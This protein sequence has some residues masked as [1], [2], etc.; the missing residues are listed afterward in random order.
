[1]GELKAVFFDVRGTLFDSK[2]CAR[3]VMDLVLNMFA[4][5]LPTDDTEEIFRRYNAVLLDQVSS[6][7]LRRMESFSRLKRFSALLES[8]GL[9]KP[10]LAREINSK[11]DATRRLMMRQFLRPDAL[12]VL[13]ALAEQG[14]KR[15][16]IVNGTLALQRTLLS[17][18]GLHE[19]LDHVVMA[20]AEGYHKPDPRLFRKALQEAAVQASEMLYVGDSPITDLLGAARAGIPVVWFNERNSPA[21]RGLPAPD[22][23]IESLAELLSI[24]DM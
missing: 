8:F 24:V 22:F 19:H 16:V 9:N 23:A 12:A 7:F 21:P 20:D 5:R 3:H 4:D 10:S 13:D 14:L 15:G 1:M 18:L 17:G 2:G 11:Y 6:A